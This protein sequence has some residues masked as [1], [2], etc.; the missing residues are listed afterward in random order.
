[1]ELCLDGG[2]WVQEFRRKYLATLRTAHAKLGDDLK[3][4]FAMAGMFSS[5][6]YVAAARI[7]GRMATH[8][9]AVF[10][11]CDVLVTPTVPIRPP[12]LAHEG[13]VSHMPVVGQTMKYIQLGNLMGLPAVTVPCGLDAASLPVG[14]APH[15]A[16]L[17]CP[18]CVLQD[19]AFYSSVDLRLVSWGL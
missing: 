5:A 14:C 6:D 1:M 10:E 11:R 15:S 8:C 13:C 16:Q 2:D 19:Y 17:C 4:A 7:R 18:L 3:F 9:L 12:R